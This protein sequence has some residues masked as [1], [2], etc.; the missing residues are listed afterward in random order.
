MHPLS[1]TPLA[2]A[3]SLTTA[4]T[5]DAVTTQTRSIAEQMRWLAAQS[6][7]PMALTLK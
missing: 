5:G 2:I 7:R 3:E 4:P 6:S 1:R